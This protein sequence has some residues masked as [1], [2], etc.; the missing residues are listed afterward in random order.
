MLVLVQDAAQAVASADV[1]VG[2][3][4]WTGDRFG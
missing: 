2:D 4:V 1:E 3:R